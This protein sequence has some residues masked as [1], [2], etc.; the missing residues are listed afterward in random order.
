VALHRRIAGDPRFV[1]G[2]VDTRFS[3]GFSHG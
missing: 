1:A 3:E 2:G